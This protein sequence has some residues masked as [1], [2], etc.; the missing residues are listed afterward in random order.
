ML[1]HM[2]NPVS[3]TENQPVTISSCRSR[4]LLPGQ[5]QNMQIRLIP[6]SILFGLDN[7]RTHDTQRLAFLFSLLIT[8]MPVHIHCYYW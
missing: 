7:Q 1:G 5:S 2:F 4:P 3:L 8:L 6:K